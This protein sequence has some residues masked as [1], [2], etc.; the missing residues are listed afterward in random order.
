MAF[1]LTA[2]L[3]FAQATEP[4]QTAPDSVRLKTGKLWTG[5]LLRADGEEVELLDEDG[6]VQAFPRSKVR[7]LS[8]P[9]ADYAEFRRLLQLAYSDRSSAEEAFGFA[10]WCRARGY[11]RD[12]ALALWRTL[13]LDE[14][15]EGAH[16]ALGHE[17]RGDAWFVPAGDGSALAWPELLRRRLAPEQPWA[18]TTMHFGVQVSGPL[19]RAVIAAAAAEYFYGELYAWF[20]PRAKLW[21]L[22]LPIEVRIWPARAR[23]LPPA[24]P[25]AAAHWDPLARVLHTWLEAE[26]GGIARPVSYERL[27]AEAVLTSAA[28]E[29]TQSTAEVP[30]WLL[31]GAGVLLEA[32]T[33]W[34][35]GLPVCDAR[36]PAQAWVAHHAALR[37][38]RTAAALAITEAA[39]F[40][41]PRAPELFA[42]S[43]TLLHFLLFDGEPS[44]AA[45]TDDFLQRALR[46]RGGGTAFRSAY[47]T[48]LSALEAAWPERV[49]RLARPSPGA[50]E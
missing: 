8:G 50:R 10:G 4:P 42:Q 17:A 23:G 13:A 27:L 28:T 37:A 26:G 22:R 36:L 16:R 3:L 45:A 25:R 18:F 49:A 31:A 41:G 39:E 43:Y 15:H 44:L 21:D 1:A 33:Q 20:Q 11:L 34:G 12:E 46:N 2:L 48:R 35:S 38:P 7:T 32:G 5:T 29:L 9:R 19:D 47:G 6:K 14:A 24:D 30:A 40:A